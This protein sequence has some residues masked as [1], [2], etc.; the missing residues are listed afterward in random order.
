[1]DPRKS[2]TRSKM[3]ISFIDTL[4]EKGLQCHLEQTQIDGARQGIFKS[5]VF[6]KGSQDAHFLLL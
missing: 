2:S 3:T 5:C 6:E 1:M 4:E